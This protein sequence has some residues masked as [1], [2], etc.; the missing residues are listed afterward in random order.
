MRTARLYSQITHVTKPLKF[1]SVDYFDNCIIKL[2]KLMDRVG[3][4]FE[5]SRFCVSERKC[6]AGV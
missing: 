3:D 5:L 1:G 2:D 6:V 4:Y